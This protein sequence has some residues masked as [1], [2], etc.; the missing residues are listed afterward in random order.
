M[1]TPHESRNVRTGV[2]RRD[3]LAH[4]AGAA[5]VASGSG[6]LASQVSAKDKES[7]TS[8]AEVAAK[9]LY[10]TLSPAQKKVIAL[11]WSDPRRTKINAN[12]SITEM[13]IG[14]FLDKAQGELV[15]RVVKGITS[16]DGYGRFLQQ[17]DEDGGGLDAYA[18]ALFG[19]PESGPFEFELTGRHLTLRADGNSNP[20]AAFG[21]PLVYGHSVKGNSPKNLFSYQTTQANKVFKAL[22]GTQRKQA[23]LAKAPGEAA[24]KLRKNLKALPGIKVGSLSSDQQQLVGETLQAIIKPYRKEDVAEAMEVVEAGGGLGELRIAFYQTGDIDNDKVW[25]VW[26]LEGPTVVCHF[27][28]APHVHAYINIA[29]RG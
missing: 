9:E 13:E 10:A 18:I 4:S 14:P 21:G 29:R 23:L 11:P 3:F 28:G 8:D 15:R 26:R 19:D 2:N 6:Y 16:E 22:D 24:V 1:A 27:R 7:K 5:V 25:D 12:W 20:G 17:M